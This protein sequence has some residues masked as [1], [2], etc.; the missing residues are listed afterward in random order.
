LLVVL[1][2]VATAVDIAAHRA[3]PYVRARV[4][5]ALSDRFHAKVELD[6]FHLALGNSLRGEWG[7]WAEGR[8]LR[9]WPPAQVEGVSAPLPSGP[10]EPLIRLG[11]FRFHVPLRYKSGEPV[12]I[13]QVR[14]KDLDIHF[15][16]KSHF[17]HAAPS[18]TAASAG[19][20][21]RNA[22]GGVKF[23]V[24]SVECTGA[25]LVLGTDKPNKLPLEFAITHLRVTGVVPGA[26]FKFEAEITNPRPPGVIHSKG[27]FG[28]WDLADPGESPVTGD[29]RFDHADLSVFTGI[30]GILESTGHYEGTLRD[31]TV[32]GETNTPDFQITRYG[33]T[34]PLHTKF[35]ARVDGTNGDTWLEPVDAMLSKSHFTAQG[36]IVRVLAADSNGSLRSVGHDISLDVNVGRARIEDFMRLTTSGPNPMLTGDVEVKAQLHIPPGTAPAHERMTLKGRFVLDKAEFASVSIRDRIK[37]LSL[38]GQG[39]PGELKNAAT[40]GVKSQMQ[41]DFQMGGGMLTLPSFTYSVPGADIDLKGSYGLTSGKLNFIGT[42]KM[43]ATISQMVGGWKGKLLRPADRFFK[44]DGAGTSIPIYVSGTREKPEF[45]YD[46]E[47]KST[48]PERPG[49]KPSQPAQ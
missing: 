40:E 5:E 47:W 11:E 35:H 20:S 7:V 21:G 46:T 1:A 36:Q 44:K 16:P 12:H 42:A 14:L 22:W 25:N 48:R 37:T 29:Y 3:E 45:G 39:R 2:A 18:Q 31:L 24:D 34:M 4:I 17:L 23:Q 49:T 32:D 6:S 19:S 10:V 27:T 15:P 41:G 43:Q 13:T 9:I 30:A 8:G 33:H 28:P 38:R 26:P